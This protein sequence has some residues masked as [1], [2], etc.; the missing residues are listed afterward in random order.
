MR[1]RPAGSPSASAAGLL[2]DLRGAL[3]RGAR[4]LALLDEEGG[5]LLGTGE[6][7]LGL[8]LGALDEAARLLVDALGL[9]HLLGHGDAELVDEVERGDL[10]D[11]DRV[12]SWA[13]G[14][15]GD[16]SLEPLDEEDD[17][18][19]AGSCWRRGRLGIVADADAGSPS[20]RAQR[21]P[22]RAPCALTSPPK[23]AISRTRVELR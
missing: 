11:H 15:L 20:S 6:D 21:R 17:V 16:E 9:A 4:Q 7:A 8:L 5:L 13:C 18:D 19:G 3:L 2:D 12:A 22:R 23:A 14:G 10:V 1:R